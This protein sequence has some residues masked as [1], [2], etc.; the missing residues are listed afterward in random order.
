MEV[1]KRP[2]VPLKQEA[3]ELARLVYLSPAAFPSAGGETRTDKPGVPYPPRTPTP[4][5]AILMPAAA[6]SGCPTQRRGPQ[7]RRKAACCMRGPRPSSLG[8]RHPGHS[9]ELLAPAVGTTVAGCGSCW[10]TETR[11]HSPPRFVPGT[12]RARQHILFSLNKSTFHHNKKSR[13]CPDLRDLEMCLQFCRIYWSHPRSSAVPSQGPPKAWL[14]PPAEWLFLAFLFLSL[15][16]S[17]PVSL[18]PL[19]CWLQSLRRG[20]CKLRIV[21]SFIN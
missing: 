8:R 10:Y 19:P 20:K 13:M 6:P 1:G 14:C 7:A 5:P 9:P 3:P 21:L 11:P 17:L 12:R 16:L 2:Q 18:P 15:S 4:A